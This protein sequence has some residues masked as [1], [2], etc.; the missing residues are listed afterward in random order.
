MESSPSTGR[1][2][3]SPAGLFDAKAT[4]AR[5]GATARPAPV[6]IPWGRLG[7]LGFGLAMLAFGGVTTYQQ[8]FVHATSD[9]VIN[10]RIAVIRA[11]IDGVVNAALGAP[12]TALGAGAA[13][14]RVDDPHPDDGRLFSLQ[15]QLA[16]AGRE[17]D[18]LTR[19]LGDLRAAEA[20]ATA[21]AD[22]YRQGRVREDEL[23]VG[24][25]EA[26][27]Q[28]ASAREANA[29]AAVTRSQAL[30]ER[31][32]VAD[33]Q[34]DQVQRAE[35]IA[36]ADALAAQKR[37]DALQVELAAA[38][39]GTFLGDSYN[40]VPSSLQRARELALQIE[41]SEASLARL[42]ETRRAL[43]QDIAAEQKR[44]AART[45]AVLAAPVKGRLWAA[46]AVSGEYVRKGQ[47]L[48]A[49]LDCASAVVTAAVGESDYNRLHLGEPVR[50]RV[51]GTG[52]EYDGHIAQLGLTVGGGDGYAIRPDPKGRQVVA[53]LSGLAADA[54]DGCA[55]GRTGTLTFEGESD[56]DA[57][58]GFVRS[59]GRLF[60]LP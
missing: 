7:K 15:Q 43:G 32:F 10:A 33:A 9:A 21:Q 14:G 24:E 18:D 8:L 38:R 42:A 60:H 30:Y 13:I 11:P 26:N 58:A 45:A 40:D 25:A 54:R 28:A 5:A 52:R 48:F 53:A 4:D 50:F 41:A 46:E 19:R 37:L 55:V 47:D 35:A 3:M 51:A 59:L 34:H 17:Q 44:L 56:G 39:A 16:A 12:G 6:A 27:L 22:I 31:G 36:R 23:R 57:A 1:L 20:Q 49:M 29:A 2:E